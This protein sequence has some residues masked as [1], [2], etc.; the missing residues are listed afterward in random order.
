MVS[1]SEETLIRLLR[2]EIFSDVYERL[3]RAP[4]PYVKR[5]CLKGVPHE[6]W[7]ASIIF[8]HIPKNAGTSINNC[9]YGRN[10]GHRSAEFYRVALGDSYRDRMTFA[11]LRNPLERF[12]SAARMFLDDQNL[13]VRIH[14]RIRRQFK[15]QMRTIDDI[16]QWA[17]AGAADPYRVDVIFRPQ[18]WFILSNSGDLLVDKLFVLGS[19]GDTLAEFVRAHTGKNLPQKNQSSKED[20]YLTCVQEERIRQI[21]ASDFVL[22]DRFMQTAP[23]H[24][25]ASYLRIS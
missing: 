11:V 22:L 23:A 5:L 2:V 16:I 15:Q 18:S 20:L 21:Y 14:P 6:I 25:D 13:D 17:E 3:S 7:G 9:F 24:D 4:F 19:D 12:A 1:V 8:I 10:I